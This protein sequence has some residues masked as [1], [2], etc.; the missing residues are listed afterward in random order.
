MNVLPRE[1]QV[2]AISALVEGVSVRATERL[3]GVNRGTI[4][5]LGIRVGEGCLKLH[6]AMMRDLHVN[7]I[8]LDEIWAFVG[9]KQRLVTHDDSDMVGD[10]YTFIALAD[11]AKAIITYKTGKRTAINTQDFADDLRARVIGSPEISTDG[12]NAYPWCIRH[13]FGEEVAHGV[14]EKHCA[15]NGSPEAARRYSPGRVT[16]VKYHAVQGAPEHISTSFVERQNL[17]LRMQ[18]RRFTRLTNGFSKNY[19][20]HCAAVALYVAHY[21]LCR[22]HE[23]LRVTPAMQLGVTDHV[24]TISELV[25]AALDGRLPSEPSPIPRRPSPQTPTVAGRKVGRFTV[26][27]GGA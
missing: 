24:W 25:G 6:S 15:V 3:T 7:R 20:N 19:L 16:T 18:Q 2:A 9:K 8:E 5:S 1:K 11:S 21:N 27:D 17:T 12:F 14:V 10:Q 13:A 22:V 23:A 26:I 4:L